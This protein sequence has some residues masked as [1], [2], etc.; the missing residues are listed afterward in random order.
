MTRADS[1][2]S[3]GNSLTVIVMDATETRPIRQAIARRLIV[4]RSRLAVPNLLAHRSPPQSRVNAQQPFATGQPHDPFP[5]GEQ[6]MP[7]YAANTEVS[8][9]KSRDEI[10]RTLTRYG[11]DQF[12]YGWQDGSAVIAF[13]AN[14][15]RVRFILPLPTR[16]SPE[17]T[18][19]SRGRREESAPACDFLCHL[20]EQ[21]LAA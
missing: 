10:E 16:E 5:S 19:S 4:I 12:M 13:R 18:Q 17:F 3:I 21:D 15:R 11:A 14:G 1:T 6:L 9:T 8:S 7:R 2:G 20:A